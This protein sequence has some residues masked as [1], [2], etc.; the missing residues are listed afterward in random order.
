MQVLLITVS[1]L[2]LAI[3][4]SGTLLISEAMKCFDDIFGN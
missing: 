1:V 3:G 2:V 4:A